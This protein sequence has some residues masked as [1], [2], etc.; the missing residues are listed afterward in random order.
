VYQCTIAVLLAVP[1]PSHNFSKQHKSERANCPKKLGLKIWKQQ[2]ETATEAELE[3]THLRLLSGTS[4]LVF[5]Y[6]SLI[7]QSTRIL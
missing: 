2:E 5:Q 1:H 6:I 4:K 3:N 7:S